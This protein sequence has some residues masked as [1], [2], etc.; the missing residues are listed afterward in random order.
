MA[1]RFACKIMAKKLILNH[2]SQRYTGLHD[3]SAS[4]IGGSESLEK[5]LKQAENVFTQGS[6]VVA[7]DFLVIPI[8]SSR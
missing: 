4:K 5:L 3:R 7:E 2:F 8:F 6:V 1:A